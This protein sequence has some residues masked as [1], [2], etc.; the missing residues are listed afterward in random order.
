MRNATALLLGFVL[1][2]M[3]GAKEWIIDQWEYR[4]GV[5]RWIVAIL[6]TAF[7]GFAILWALAPIVWE[8]GNWLL[9]AFG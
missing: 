6:L 4:A 9:I 5:G 2:A 7:L 1:L 3:A 8:W